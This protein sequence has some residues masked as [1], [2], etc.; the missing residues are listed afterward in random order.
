MGDTNSRYTRTEDTGIR[1]FKSQNNL[2][3]AWVSLIKGGVYP[4]A[5]ADADVCANPST[6]LTCETVDK[7]LYRGS[8]AITLT[9]KSFVYDGNEFLNTDPA[10]LG[11]PLSDHNPELV[12]FNWAMSSSF[13]Q[14]NFWGGPH[15]TWFNDLPS[16]PSSPVLSKITLHGGSR[17]DNVAAMLSTGAAFSHGGTG[18]TAVSLTLASGEYWTSAYVCQ[19]TYNSQTRIFYIK[20]TTS[21]GNTVAAGK[22][23][24]DCTAFTADDGYAIVGYL[25]Q[26]GDEVD[27][28]GFIYAPKQ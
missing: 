20:A 8:K 24:S 1:V 21:N 11:S 23:T 22:T 15:G 12:Y 2:S 19:G 26:S 4:T 13:R 25:G 10:Y 18:G 7:V 3:D 16:M 9:A 28:L 5:G 14:S 27:Q 17:I 6:T